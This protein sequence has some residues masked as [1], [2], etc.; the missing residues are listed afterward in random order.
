[1]LERNPGPIF[2]AKSKTNFFSEEGKYLALDLGGTNFR[3]LL[4]EFQ[5][6]EMVDTKVNYY[7]VADH[8]RLG[9]G[10]AL[11]DFLADCIIDFLR[12]QGLEDESL[13]LGM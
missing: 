5:A 13:P 9:N 11:F 4:A 8:L 3:V 2:A 1:M 7:H 10:Q 12:Q 6:G